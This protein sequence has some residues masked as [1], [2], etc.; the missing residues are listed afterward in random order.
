MI[1]LARAHLDASRALLAE[2][3]ARLDALADEAGRLQD[4]IEALQ[5]FIDSADTEVRHASVAEPEAAG[6]SPRPVVS[7]SSPPRPARSGAAAADRGSSPAGGDG[8]TGGG[9]GARAS[10]SA[11]AAPP[12]VCADCGRSFAAPNALAIHRGR[13]HRSERPS[14]GPEPIQRAEAAEERRSERPTIAE[15][16]AARDAQRNARSAPP[17]SLPGRGDRV[18]GQ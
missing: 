6:F 18:V 17:L 2:Q 7:G 3:Q 10:A 12:H 11:P 4:L 15:R 16:I 8:T 14:P 5:S 13:T 9:R 1:E